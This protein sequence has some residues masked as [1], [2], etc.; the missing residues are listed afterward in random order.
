[1]KE[2]VIQKIE[3]SVREHSIRKNIRNMVWGIFLMT[4]SVLAVRQTMGETAPQILPF[5]AGGVTGSICVA[6]ASLLKRKIS[7]ARIAVILPWLMILILYRPG[8]WIRGFQWWVNQMISGWNQTYDGGAALYQIQ[9]GER[10]QIAIVVIL[11]VLCGELSWKL[12]AE[13]RSFFC[14]MFCFILIL[15]QLL[16][17][18]EELRS[19]IWLLFIQ[20]SVILSNGELWPT[21]RTICWEAGIFLFILISSLGM[22]QHEMQSVADFRNQAEEKVHEWRYGVKSLPEGDLT[23]SSM[24][25]EHTEEM[26][27]VQ[28]G[29]EKT[30]YL[31]GYTGGRYDR[32]TG[33]WSALS[34]ADY[35]NENSGM[36]EWLKQQGFDPLTQTADYY[37]LGEESQIPEENILQIS[38]SN[39]QREYFYL[40]E[41]LEEVKKGRAKE[42]K[43][44]GLRSRGLTGRRKYELQELSGS[45][46]AE[47]TMAQQWV[48]DPQNEKQQKYLEAEAVYRNFVYENEMGVDTKLRSLIQKMFWDDYRTQQDGIYSA[49]TQI[50]TVLKDPHFYAE[51]AGIAED[52]SDP[53]S[54]FL[55]GDHNANDMFYATAAVLAFRV[56]GIPARYAEGYYV[57]DKM[58]Q[59]QGGQVSV[60]GQNAH[61]WVEVYFDG[62][63]WLP[64]DVT[65]GYY[66]ESVD[67]QQMV[68]IPDTIQKTAAIENSQSEADQFQGGKKGTESLPE[69]AVRYSIYMLLGV[70]TI[71][72]VLLTAVITGLEAVRWIWIWNRKH[73]YKKAD[74]QKR[75]QILHDLLY[76]LLVLRGIEGKLGWK[77]EETDLQITEKVDGIEPGMYRKVCSLLEKN[78]YGGIELEAY[79][80]RTLKSFLEKIIQVK[81]KDSLQLKLKIRY[82]IIM[83]ND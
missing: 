36:L 49:L 3:P 28:T 22:S 76:R 12:V 44:T 81:K 51:K 16:S 4:I 27:T 30:L 10:D 65:P 29:Q 18:S 62:I 42:E 80:E 26:M 60:T 58:I 50:R 63:G 6:A 1:M 15:L 64:V 73:I 5:L 45:R 46:P 24:L 74:P 77:T 39:A 72:I 57:S 7:F 2:S 13:K 56:Y 11:S 40:P 82:G 33:K 14:G 47:L 41:S 23:K 21:R 54:W 75:V 52:T 48:S 55:T 38:I 53:V 31:R 59:E 61:A 35:G 20:I 78:I 19:C 70:V 68:S 9:S 69:K 43:D 83:K 37:R 17:G 67:L 34:E 32:D 79:E 25:R 8:E 66:Y 71:L